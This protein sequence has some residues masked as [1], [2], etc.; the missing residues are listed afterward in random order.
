MFKAFK[1]THD[2]TLQR[3]L[4]GRRTCDLIITHWT[5]N[6]VLFNADRTILKHGFNAEN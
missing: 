6:H 1:Q 5:R 2:V 3:A 4:L